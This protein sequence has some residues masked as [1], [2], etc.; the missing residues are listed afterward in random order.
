MFGPQGFL[1]DGERA[2]VV[3]LGFDVLA[4]LPV[5]LRQI[6]QHPPHVGVIGAE[7]FLVHGQRAAI[8]GLGFTIL[9]LILI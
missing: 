4:L 7:R 9:A 2:P 3:R 6:V 8:Q 5:Q 1:R